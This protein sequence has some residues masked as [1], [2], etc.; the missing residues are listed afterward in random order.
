MMALDRRRPRRVTRVAAAVTL[1]ATVAFTGLL[2]PQRQRLREGIQNE[3][4]ENP[5][6][7]QA[8][9]APETLD[10]MA[11]EPESVGANYLK[12]EKKAQE[13]SSDNSDIDIPGGPRITKLKKPSTVTFGGG[14]GIYVHPEGEEEPPPSAKR[15]SG[16]ISM[17]EDEPT[18]VSRPPETKRRAP[19][20]IEPGHFDYSRWER[21]ADGVSDTA[22]TGDD[23]ELEWKKEEEDERRAL[24]ERQ[25]ETLIQRNF[26]ALSN[27]NILGEAARFANLTLRDTKR[28]GLNNSDVLLNRTGLRPEEALTIKSLTLNGARRKEYFWRQTERE[29]D[30]FIIVPAN[31]SHK[32]VRVSQFEIVRP[33]PLV[34]FDHFINVT[35]NGKQFF[36]RQLPFQVKHEKVYDGGVMWSLCDFDGDKSIKNYCPPLR[37]LQIT[38]VKQHYMHHM[39]KH[40]WPRAFEGEP[41]INIEY[42]PGRMN[43]NKT[44]NFVDAWEK[45]H[46]MFRERI[47]NQKKIPIEVSPEQY[48]KAKIIE[49]R[50]NARREKTAKEW[51]LPGVETK[52]D[53]WRLGEVSTP[54]APRPNK[55]KKKKTIADRSK[56]LEK[57]P[58][59]ETESDVADYYADP[60]Y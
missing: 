39:V 1:M 43:L 17:P 55:E 49:Q 29:V 54:V 6:T 50:V 19:E 48:R 26:S 45:A 28:L 41:D 51:A 57:L 5:G 21:L 9:D 23:P 2:P 12:W 52:H 18:A 47:K 10:P 60:D 14:G 33:P 34:Q 58:I 8:G 27:E 3:N 4:T 38:V 36:K 16:T 22:Y 46:E 56:R 25:R 37:L 15:P 53:W 30:I 20:I 35:I 31:T 13:W 11:V 40:W 24:Y 59:T 32:E 7:K 42:I 44:R